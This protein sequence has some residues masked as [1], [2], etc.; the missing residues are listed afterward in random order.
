MATGGRKSRTDEIDVRA[1]DRSPRTRTGGK[2]KGKGRGG[3]GG[4]WFAGGRLRWLRIAAGVA[5]VGAVAGVAALTGLFVYYGNDPNLPNIKKLSD[6]KPPQTSRVYDRNGKLIGTLGPQRRTVVPFAKIPK[7]LVQAVVAAEDPHYFQH[8]GVDYRGILRAF[9]ENT[10]RLRW[11]RSAQ[12][13]ST[14]TQQVVK[15]M[16]LTR[17]KTLRRKVQ[18]MILARQLSQSLSKEEILEIYLN[19]IN[20]GQA[21]YGCEEGA[22]Y[23]FGKSVTEIDLAEAA[24]LAGVPQ[25]P[26]LLSPYKNPQAAKNRQVYVLAQMAKHGYVPQK[27][28]DKLAAE[29]LPIVPQATSQPG[30]APEAVDAVYRL[31]VE[32]HGRE[33][34][35]TLGTTVKTTIDLPLQE[36][37]R[38]AVERGLED[39]DGRQG[40][41]GPTGRGRSPKELSRRRAELAKARN[42]VL[43]ESAIVEGIVDK[44][45]RDPANPKG[46]KLFVDVG[47][48]QGVVDLA[49]ETR[50]GEGPKPLAERFR[51]GDYVRVRAAPERRRLGGADDKQL[52]LALELGPQAAMVVMDPRSREI[53]ALVGGYNFR[54]GGFDRAQRA[55]RQAGSTFKPFVYAAAID[56]GRYTAASVVN[57]APEVYDLW[58]PENYEKGSFR[59]PVRLRIA[60]ADSINT[61]PI[62][63]LHD[64]KVPTVKELAARAGITT[65]MADDL[66]LSLALGA[67]SVSPLELAN[68]YA[69]FATAG[70]RDEARLVTAMGGEALERAVAQKVLRP[71]TAY[72]VTSMMRSVV[73]TG[74]ARAAYGKLRRPIAG[75]TGTS[76]GQKDAWFAG[77]TP[78]LLAVVWVGFDD[79]RSLGAGEAGGK[80]ALPIWTDFMAKALS[81]RPV[82]DF[83]QPPGITVV[84]IDPATG[85]LAPTGAEGI[86]EVFLAGT[87]PKETAPTQGEASTADQVL[88]ER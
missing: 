13:G 73:E 46:G 64:L 72:I 26:E 50:Y 67:A 28:A 40:Y 6:Y 25:I 53:L 49:A 10:L 18:E 32:K 55:L 78:D 8:E 75:K 17:E 47:G 27:T 57:D 77:F 41:R 52:L 68:A 2:G 76:N 86:D 19:Q 51:P 81:G 7:I 66:N 31:L 24:F 71:E 80:T 70:D 5:L 43:R 33:A 22:R 11:G 21:R 37:A 48:L 20:Y 4:G 84:R 30:R 63:L 74:T 59:G 42:G 12:G 54:A 88:L 3:K 62:K 83:A 38:E 65:P 36:L 60:L 14:I 34:I 9:V 1:A 58:K 29:P 44:V 15:N 23:Y 79:G 69:T 61:I 56:S 85:L 45:E 39:L 82:K 16:L 87:E 35:P